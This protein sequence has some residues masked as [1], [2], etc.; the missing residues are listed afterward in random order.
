MV[1][2]LLGFSFPSRVILICT[3]L[4]CISLTRYKMRFCYAHFP[5][6]VSVMKLRLI[7]NNTQGHAY[8]A[9]SIMPQVTLTNNVVEIRNF[10]GEKRLESVDL[11][12]PSYSQHCFHKLGA[13]Y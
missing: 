11:L 2:N 8:D 7:T 6:N 13:L 1:L 4:V 12:L 10:L 5:I 9:N 3:N